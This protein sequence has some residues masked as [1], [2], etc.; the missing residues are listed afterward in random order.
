[1]ALV[2]APRKTLKERSREV[3]SRKASFRKSGHRYMAHA[4]LAGVSYW[5]T[6]KWFNGERRSARCQAAYDYLIAHPRN[7]HA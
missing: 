7:G 6:W 5:M 1:M 2:L 3:K 4:Q